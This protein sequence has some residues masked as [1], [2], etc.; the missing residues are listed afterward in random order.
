MVNLDSSDFLKSARVHPSA[1]D[2]GGSTGGLLRCELAKRLLNDV[3]LFEAVLDAG[4]GELLQKR[5]IVLN[6]TS[7]KCPPSERGMET[8]SA[9]R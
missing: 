1:H 7:L 8:L 5:N 6:K 3:A 4:K 9:S 2:I